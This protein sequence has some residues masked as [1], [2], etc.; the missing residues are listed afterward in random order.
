MGFVLVC[1]MASYIYRTWNRLRARQIALQP[2]IQM[3]IL[4]IQ[5][6]DNSNENIISMSGS[7]QLTDRHEETAPSGI[8]STSSFLTSR[9]GS[10]SL[11]QQS[12]QEV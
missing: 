1:L 4:Q 12:E 10:S 11:L 8:G 6:M 5:S 7:Q 9:S 2:P 3:E